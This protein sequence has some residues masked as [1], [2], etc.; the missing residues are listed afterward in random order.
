MHFHGTVRSIMLLDKQ[1]RKWARQICFKARRQ[2]PQGCPKYHQCYETKVRIHWFMMF[3]DSLL[4]QLSLNVK[5]ADH[6]KRSTNMEWNN[7]SGITVM[8][9]ALRVWWLSM[10]NIHTYNYEA[11]RICNVSWVKHPKVERT[12]IRPYTNSVQKLSFAQIQRQRNV[13]VMQHRYLVRGTP[14]YGANNLCQTKGWMTKCFLVPGSHKFRIIVYSGKCDS[15]C[16]VGSGLCYKLFEWKY[17]STG[18][19]LGGTR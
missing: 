19:N 9:H 4:M 17:C 18:E 1:A 11:A 2:L 6:V 13:N 12:K 8:V 15:A 10:E 5:L 16:T 14:T 7:V 3:Q